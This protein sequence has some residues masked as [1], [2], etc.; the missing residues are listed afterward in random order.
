MTNRCLARKERPDG[1]GIKNADELISREAAESGLDYESA[2]REVVA[3]AL[4]DILPDSSFLEDLANN[5][6][7]IFE[8]LYAKFKEFAA[9]IKKHFA[10]LSPNANKAA[11][12]LKQGGKYVESVLEA[13]NKA[14]L[15]AVENYQAT[16]AEQQAEK[17]VPEESADTSKIE[18][19]S[20]K[21]EVQ[22]QRRESYAPGLTSGKPGEG[23]SYEV[24][25]KDY[26]LKE[27]ANMYHLGN[28]G[29][30]YDALFDKVYAFCEN[31]GTQFM[32]VPFIKTK[33]GRT[34]PGLNIGNTIKLSA[35]ALNRTDVT[36]ERKSKTILHEMLHASTVYAITAYN[37]AKEEEI[38]NELPE[39]IRRSCEEFL[40]VYEAIKKDSSFDGQYA[41]ESVEE[42]VA[43]LANPAFVKELKRS[44][45]SGWHMILQGICNI[46]GIN[47][48]FS[49]YDK[50]RRAAERILSDPDFELAQG[51]YESLQSQNASYLDETQYADA[52]VQEQRR[53]GR[54]TDQEVLAYAVD[55]YK[56]D[57]T[58]AEGL[59]E[60]EKGAL[61]V[62]EKRLGKLD[63]LIA[64]RAEQGRI[65]RENTFQKGGDRSIAQ[66]AHNRMEVPDGQ[67]ARSVADCIDSANSAAR[68]T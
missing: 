45:P 50:L 2:S 6:K 48:S 52:D 19:E 68:S 16:V 10:S 56:S 62:F 55:L 41:L 40:Q 33:D 3:E 21:G 58:I 49:N 5:H 42:M 54:M 30:E 67:I 37:M 51:Y 35:N 31:V 4:T 63:D 38:V 64:E 13:F 1:C 12:T 15:G 22:N 59:T 61:G 25:A 14:A 66:A 29:S 24:S 65:Y 17:V 11:Q 28:L 7:N 39:H 47:K 53:D 57:A 46:L 8:K 34:A 27:V 18:Q 36:N 32:G 23:M 60:A 26:T 20:A 44:Y 9:N 43:E